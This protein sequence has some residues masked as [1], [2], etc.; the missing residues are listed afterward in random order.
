MAVP[1]ELEARA[2]QETGAVL[3]NTGRLQETMTE[4]K[5]TRAMLLELKTTKAEL[6][7]LKQRM[8]TIASKTFTQPL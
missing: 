8:T 6:M 3:E 2:E 4:L 7:E 1:E 5:R